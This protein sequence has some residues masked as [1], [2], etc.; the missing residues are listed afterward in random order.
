MSDSICDLIA[1]GTDTIFRFKPDWTS[2]PTM[3]ITTGRELVQYDKA[4]MR[5]RNLTDKI[6]WNV[7]MKFFNLTKANEYD[8]LQYFISHRGM[9]N[10][11]WL[12][13]RWNYF[14]LYNSIVSG[15]KTFIPADS[16]FEY[17]A[18][19]TERIFILLKNGDM[20]TRQILEQNLIP[21]PVEYTV[22]TA[23]DRN[24]A[25][26]DIDILGK[27]ILCRFDQDELQFNYI[28]TELSELDL[29]FREL[30]QEY[31]S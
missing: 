19:C 3:E 26:I 12:P 8:I 2:R 11:F 13:V 23:F 15:S 31:V 21:S 16:S 27:L 7:K 1:C 30:G 9:V 28:S 14:S 6:S 10:K 18:K 24:I 4:A 22:K 29:S 25:Q 20:L 5:Y 17:I